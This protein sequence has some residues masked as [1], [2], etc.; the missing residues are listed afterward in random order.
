MCSSHRVRAILRLV[1]ASRQ[2][3]AVHGSYVLFCVG[4]VKCN[5]NSG[6]YPLSHTLNSD[7]NAEI[8]E[9]IAISDVFLVDS[10]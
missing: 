1:C 7:Q 10:I 2:V 8:G 9:K 4:Y 5:E 3:C 6:L